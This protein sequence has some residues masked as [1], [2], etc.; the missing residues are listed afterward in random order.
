MKDKDGIILN[1]YGPSVMTA[2]IEPGLSVTL[3]QE[4]EYPIAGRIEIGVAL[5]KAADLTLKLRIPYWSKKT[6]VKLN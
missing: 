5:S 1:Y 2:D 4:T 3:T 6:K